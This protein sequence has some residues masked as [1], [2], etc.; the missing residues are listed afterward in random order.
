MKTLIINDDWGIGSGKYKFKHT[1]HIGNEPYYNFRKKSIKLNIFNTLR[2]F[3]NAAKLG[4]KYI[5]S[6]V[7]D[8]NSPLE[9]INNSNWMQECIEKKIRA[10]K[11][12]SEKIDYI[13]RMQHSDVF[14]AF[15][16]YSIFQD[17]GKYVEITEDKYNEYL[18]NKELF[19]RAI[20]ANIFGEK[21]SLI[22]KVP[23]ITEQH[24]KDAIVNNIQYEAFEC[25]E[26]NYG[27]ID[28]K[29]YLI[30]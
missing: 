3:L 8:S 18:K 25:I 30:L 6:T 26:K 15:W 22:C 17:C 16:E 20:Y 12:I 4:L 7:E 5:Y 21:K 27:K 2:H 9:I 14:N 1:I 24:V 13:K 10:S 19:K 29:Y 11:Y 23:I 28:F